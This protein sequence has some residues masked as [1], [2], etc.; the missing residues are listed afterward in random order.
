MFSSLDLASGYFQ[1]RIAKEDSH[2]TAFCTPFCQYE[3]RLLPMGLCNAPSSFMQAM[4]SV[5]DKNITDE[6]YKFAGVE[7]SCNVL[8]LAR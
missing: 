1:L 8:L 4:N 3:W 6:D 2:K 7:A 5:F